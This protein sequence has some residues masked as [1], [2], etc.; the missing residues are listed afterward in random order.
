M[1]I[2]NPVILLTFANPAAV[3][4]AYL[5]SLS[6]E[7]NLVYRHLIQYE[8]DDLVNIDRLES[9][10][11]EQV[12]DT[13]DAWRKRKDIVLFHYGG[14]ADGGNLLLTNEQGGINTSAATG[15][16]RLLGQIDTL[17]LVFLNGC[18]T[19]PQVQL[20][21]DNGIKA[22]IAT[23]VPVN[24]DMAVDFADRFYKD[25]GSGST[26]EAAFNQ[27]STFI[28]TKYKAQYGIDSPAIFRSMG[29]RRETSPEEESIPWGL[30]LNQGAEEVLSWRLPQQTSL[31]SSYSLIDKYTCN[32]SEQNSRFKTHF[33][34]NRLQTKFLYFLIHGVEEQSP[35]GLF[36]RF[37][38]EHIATTYDRFFHKIHPLESASEFEEAKM[39]AITAFFQAL[40][41]NPNR[42][43]PPDLNLKTLAN[44]KIAK[45][46]D[47][48]AIMFR[49][50]SSEWKSFTP[51]YIHWVVNE[52][53]NEKELPPDSPDFFLFVNIIYDEKEESG[54]LFSKLF[55][56]SPRQQIVKA[57]E[58]FQT[59]LPLPEL[60]PV[61]QQDVN[62]WFDR[63]TEDPEVK[64]KYIQQYFSEKKEMAMS[65]VEKKLEKII[66][67]F[68]S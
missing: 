14:H 25:F 7:S 68:N 56:K 33:L 35:N 23:S 57:V 45:E 10:S 1:S 21:L 16:A 43:S 60:P 59:I 39:N 11:V 66:E 52:F 40:E 28:E 19:Y 42:Y 67:E 50:Y 55:K 32:R 51:N 54:G 31:R 18:S 6:K 17:Q 12:F 61:I 22:V 44:S 2:Q 65:R 53:C 29:R 5:S 26:V 3:P 15:L 47:C 36:N 34:K 9:A 27:A 13:V 64:R 58:N 46:M 62:K 24:D 30:Y 41:L 38:L 8:I 4:E 48:V 20:L 37:V 63:L 49:I